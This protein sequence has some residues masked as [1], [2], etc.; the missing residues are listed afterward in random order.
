[1]KIGVISD[2]HD[3]LIS[4]KKALQLFKANNVEMILHCGDW[5]SPFTVE[6]LSQNIDV[7]IKGVLGN[8]KG[9]IK[10]TLQR[11]SE[12][13]N[14]VEF[15][16][17]ETF[18]LEIDGKKIAVYHGDDTILL[19]ALISSKNYD[20]IFTGHTH[21]TRN[22]AIDGALIVNPGTTCYASEGKII[23]FASIAIYDTSKHSAELIK[24]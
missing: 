16:K 8:N 17:G 23:D 11:N 19:N 10:R 9:D 18:E 15:P 6:F 1:M 21:T 13:K 22:E 24:F 4:L 12:L 3:N 14:P 2:T 5:V 20:V 7:P